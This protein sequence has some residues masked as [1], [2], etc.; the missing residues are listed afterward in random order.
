LT[1]KVVTY[2]EGS[3]PVK[4]VVYYNDDF[5]GRTIEAMGNI[6]VNMILSLILFSKKD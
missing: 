1:K 5:F 3:D 2:Y 6:V 4:Q